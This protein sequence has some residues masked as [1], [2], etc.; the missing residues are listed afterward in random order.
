M[1]LHPLLIGKLPQKKV[2]LFGIHFLKSLTLIKLYVLV[3]ATCII[4]FCST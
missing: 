4:N 3:T 2:V 1:T